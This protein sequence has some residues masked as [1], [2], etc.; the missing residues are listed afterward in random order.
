MMKVLFWQHRLKMEDADYRY[1]HHHHRERQEQ[2]VRYKK[3]EHAVGTYD[4]Q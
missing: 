3:C 4:T 2:W 1:Q